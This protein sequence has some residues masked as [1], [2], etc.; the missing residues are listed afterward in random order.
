MLSWME[1]MLPSYIPIHV[2]FY[3]YYMR[4][5]HCNAI[6]WQAIVLPSQSVLVG[7]TL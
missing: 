7:H 5:L 1:A 4:P 2:A 3:Q 6:Q